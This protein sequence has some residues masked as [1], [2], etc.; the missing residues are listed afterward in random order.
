MFSKIQH[1]LGLSSIFLFSM[2]LLKGFLSWP[3]YSH[4][5]LEEDDDDSDC[6]EN[7]S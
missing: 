1:M 7:D 6:D 3:N 5:L 4:L 2:L